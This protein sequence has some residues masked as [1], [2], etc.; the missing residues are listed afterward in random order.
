MK[1]L[2]DTSQVKGSFMA[3]ENRLD[4]AEDLC[5]WAESPDEARAFLARCA[6]VGFPAIDRIFV[7]KTSP[8]QR[9][10]AYVSGVYRPTT[11]DQNVDVFDNTLLAPDAITD[12]AQWCTC[13]VVLSHGPTPFAALE[14]TTHIVRINLYQ[15]IPRLARAALLGVPSLILQGTYGLDLEMRGDRWALYRYLQ[16]FAGMAR[17][18]PSAPPLP[19]W[20]L[21]T[22]AA[23]AQAADHV[24]QHLKALAVADRVYV[25]RER[26]RALS[27][28]RKLLRD[29]IEGD[30][31]PDLPSIRHD[32]PEVVVRIG[33]QPDRKSWRAKGSGQMD[34]Y[35]GMI[36]AAKYIYCHDSNGEQT[37]PLI[38]EFAYLP[39]EFWFFKDRENATALYKRLPFEFADEVR[40]LG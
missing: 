18:F 38:V 28:I 12:L 15:R 10:S 6:N 33:A 23:E 7:A 4:L 3:H 20:Y 14:D 11:D 9:T 32:G 39:T 26:R 21:P 30:I 35:I 36:A 8:R 13:D 16:A 27:V 24:L 37:R 5:L 34:P 29:G 1:R 19:V 22:S 17:C 2:F 25:N 40:F 31:P